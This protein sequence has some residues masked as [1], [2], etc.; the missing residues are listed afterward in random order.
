[1]PETADTYSLGFTVTPR[2][3]PEFAATIDYFH[4]AQTNLVSSIPA[5]V[6]YNGC[7]AN[8]DPKY[9]S[10][11]VRNSVGSIQGASVAGGGYILQ[12]D[13]NTGRGLFSGVD[14]NLAWRQ[15]LASWGALTLNLNGSYL[16][17]ATSTPYD[18]AHTYDCAGLYG[19]TCNNGVNP[20]WRHTLRANWETP[21]SK[22]LISGNWRFIGKSGNEGNSPDPTLNSGTYDAFRAYIPNYSYFDLSAVW[23]IGHGIT[24]RGGMNNLFDKNPP[25]IGSDITA[26]GSPNTYPTY[27]LLGREVFVSFSAKY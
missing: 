2:S 17:H 18:G 21:W 9:C 10:Q 16:Q 24:L 12:T 5:D 19:P 23:P 15:R 4:I 8:G 20:R 11:I 13:V 22:L 6:I 3:L 26:T 1:M 25:I 7:L 14:V 27:D